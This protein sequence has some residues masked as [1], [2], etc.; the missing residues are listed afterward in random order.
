MVIVTSD[1]MQMNPFPGLRPFREEEE[2]LFFG[3]ENQVDAMVDKLSATRFLAVIGTSGSGKSSL[4]NCGLR[5]ALHGGLMSR[6]GTAWRMVQFRPGSNPLV[7]M[8]SALAKDGV[9]FD[10]FQSESLTLTEIVE[11]TLRMSKLGLIDIYEQAKLDKDVN[12]LIVV[13]QFEEL[14]RYRQLDTDQKEK[15]YSIGEEVT[16]FVNL[17]LEAKAQIQYP[18]YVVLT[19]RSDFLGD[20]TQLPGLA[21]AI[22]AGQYLVPRMT[23][24]ERR[25]AIS[26][27]IG[28]GGAEIT[29]VL[30]TRLVNDVG[31]NPDQLSILQH[32]LNRTWARWQK[33]GGSGPLDLP[34]YQGIGTMAHALDQHAEKVYS[35]LSTPRQRQIC[36]KLFKA[37]TDKATDPRGIRRPTKIGTLC[38]LTGGTVA[39]VSEVIEVFRKPSRSFLMPPAEEKLEAEKVIDISHESLMRVWQR[40]NCWADEEAR[41]ARTYRRLSETAVLYADDKADLLQGME[42]QLALNWRQE[43]K[44]TEVW[45]NLYQGNFKA[46]MNFLRE[47]KAQRDEQESAIIRSRRIKFTYL[48]MLLLVVLLTILNSWKQQLN[49]LDQAKSIANWNQRDQD[50]AK[51]N[52]LAIYEIYNQGNYELA[53][54]LEELKRS[55]PPDMQHYSPIVFG[56]PEFPNRL[57]KADCLLFSVYKSLSA[58]NSQ[59]D[60]E[61][62]D[63]KVHGP[64]EKDNKSNQIHCEKLSAQTALKQLNTKYPRTNQTQLAKLAIEPHAKEALQNVFK[65][66]EKYKNHSKPLFYIPS[67][68]SYVDGI[69]NEDIRKFENLEKKLQDYDTDHY[70][71]IKEL[72]K[73][74]FPIIMDKELQ[75]ANVYGYFINDSKFESLYEKYEQSK[76]LK[77]LRNDDN[78]IY[79]NLANSAANDIEKEWS[80]KMF[81]LI[82]AL[83]IA[84]LSVI[85]M[86]SPIIYIWKRWGEKRKWPAK[87]VEIETRPN[88]FPRKAAGA[89]DSVSSIVIGVFISCRRIAAGIID[90][91]LSIV[92]GVFIAYF[93]VAVMSIAE[94][95]GNS[96][97]DD[98]I[99]LGVVLGLIG[100]HAYLLFRDAIPYRFYRSIGKIIFGLL[101]VT[102]DGRPVTMKVSAKRNFSLLFV[103]YLSIMFGFIGFITLLAD[104]LIWMLLFLLILFILMIRFF[105]AYA[106]FPRRT[107]WDRMSDTMVINV[108]DYQP[109][110]GGDWGVYAAEVS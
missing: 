4:V 61:Q 37:L 53:N 51:K 21:E 59:K 40:L 26:G 33:D 105:F 57:D 73:K 109:I 31:D 107:L 27:P 47:S 84:L 45:A 91:A 17:L 106:S 7:A 46:S 2:Y 3:R 72:V 28:V 52:L 24:D 104:D 41:S 94:S 11:T 32:A 23:R 95:L 63:Q 22:N 1:N 34:H 70:G 62:I 58:D 88:P 29:T 55:I 56:L 30:L 64:Q 76:N 39:E 54:R 44:P 38:A 80:N 67:V 49:E 18:I 9:L 108:N 74:P 35:E 101:P 43:Q 42:L 10:H 60:Q 110:D 87:V 14:F 20:C 79:R 93:T 13:D 69:A 97:Q 96:E 77:L 82:A 85:V 19:M 90:F 66:Y 92:I 102:F 99:I 83:I 89:I 98:S 103:C 48:I 25:A 68:R 81:P 12:L 86:V 50:Q 100:M 65:L 75:L 71:I 36:E 78:P 16:A 8:S 6:A 5:P 15:A